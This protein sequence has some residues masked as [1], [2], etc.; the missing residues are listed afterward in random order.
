MSALFTIILRAGIAA[1]LFFSLFGQ[2]V[3]IPNSGVEELRRILPDGPLVTAYMVLGIIGVACVQTVLVAVWALLSMVERDAVFSRKAFR[4]LDVII[5]AGAA[6]TLLS[7]GVAVHL[8]FVHLD[9][10]AFMS[11]MFPTIA[12][13]AAAVS[14]S[15]LMVIM[16]GLVGKAAD[17]QTEMAEVV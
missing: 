6:L 2:A 15:M 8:M 17:L 14:F 5:G 3:I 1:T 11:L 12:C 4:W 10:M 9:E 13:L 16:R 7:F